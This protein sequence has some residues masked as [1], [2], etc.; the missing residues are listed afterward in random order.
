MKKNRKSAIE[1]VILILRRETLA[2]GVQRE[3]HIQRLFC[4]EANMS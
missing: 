3:F 4:V 2:S 1:V